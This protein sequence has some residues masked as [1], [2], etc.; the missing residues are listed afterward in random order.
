MRGKDFRIG[1][2]PRSNRVMKLLIRQYRLVAFQYHGSTQRGIGMVL[3]DMFEQM[4]AHQL[5]RLVVP[6]F[7]RLCLI[8]RN[9]ASQY[10]TFPIKDSHPAD[11]DTGTD[12]RSSQLDLIPASKR[13]M[14][15]R[16]LFIHFRSHH[17]YT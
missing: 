9:L 11:P 6:L 12:R 4:I 13:D 7:F 5:Y 2:N 3:L 17:H 15:R 16:P 14:L 10:Y 8:R 1:Y